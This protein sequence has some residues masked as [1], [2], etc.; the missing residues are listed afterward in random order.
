VTLN[1]YDLNTYETDV[2][3]LSSL[4]VNQVFKEEEKSFSEGKIN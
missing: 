1:R 4:E 3:D 2:T